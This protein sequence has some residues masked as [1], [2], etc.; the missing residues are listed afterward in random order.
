MSVILEDSPSLFLGYDPGGDAANGVSVFAI[1][2]GARA[3]ATSLVE[4]VDAALHWFEERLGGREPTA[5]GIETYLFWE[6]GTG[7]WRAAD[8][9]LREQYP[10]V[11]SSVFCSNSAAG[12]M[13]IQGMALAIAAK[14]RWPNVRLAEA[15]PKVLYFCLTSKKYEWPTDM[16][17]WLAHETSVSPEQP[18]GTEHEWDA[19]LSAWAAYQ[20]SQGLWQRDLRSLSRSAI[21]PAGP[22]SYWWPN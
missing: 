19:L 1:Q 14:R 17:D 11:R 20:G 16:R 15:H 12:S 2:G 5:L 9:W 13:A 21:E 18:V 10:T 22:V 8:H 3:C 6:T 7:G 4:S